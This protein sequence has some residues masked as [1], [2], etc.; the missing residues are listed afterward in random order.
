MHSLVL[1]LVPPGTRQV[2]AWIQG[3][4]L[5]FNEHVDGPERFEAM[6][7]AELEEMREHYRLDDLASLSARMEDWRRCPGAV[8]DGRLGYVTTANPQA[9]MDFCVVGGAWDGQLTGRRVPPRAAMPLRIADALLGGRLLREGERRVERNT[10]AARECT[11][12]AVELASAVVT[13]DAA[14]IDRDD[15]TRGLVGDEASSR[16]LDEVRRVLAHH[17]GCDVVVVDYHH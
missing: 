9:R 3:H 15:V 12:A 5:P 13:P 10:L 11:P 17:A 2:D 4:L 6:T 1:V 8:R 16:W 14:W 7:G